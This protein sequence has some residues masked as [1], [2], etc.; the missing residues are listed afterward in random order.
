[1]HDLLASAAQMYYVDQ[2][3]QR[4]I[5]E[6][7]GVSRSTISRLLKAAR[8]RG[9]VKISVDAFDPRDRD[10]EAALKERFGLHHAIV[11]RA[12]GRPSGNVRRTVGYFAAAA[13]S[14]LIRTGLMLGIAGG[15]TLAAM[16]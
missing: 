15:R 10:R 14:E 1:S 8:E 12:P 4:E 13:V 5:G 6:L 9:I 11:I 16:V 2:L 7:L 3:D